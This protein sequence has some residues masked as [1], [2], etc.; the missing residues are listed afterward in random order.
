MCSSDLSVKGTPM[1]KIGKG[2]PR[3]MVVAGIHGNELAPP[4]AALKLID[5]LSRL[6]LKGTIYIIPF[7]CPKAS[8]DNRRD[9]DGADLNR[10]GHIKGSVSNSILDKAKELEV[11]AI[12]DFHSTA[13]NTNPGKEAVFCSE[14]PC[15]A[16]VQ[17]ADF[18]ELNA[19]SQ[20]IVYEK[21][22]ALFKG[23]VEDESNLMGIPAVTCEVASPIKYADKKIVERS[24]IQM[25]SFLS[26]FGIYD[27]YI[28]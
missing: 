25:R 6:E 22:G 9:F 16:S 17:I 13:P 28:V 27:N 3:L 18:I 14:N 24:L 7:A 26:Y 8:M 19:G 20:K 2:L 15:H 11:S 10:A 4:I 23:A 1:V 21:A 12:G 5:E